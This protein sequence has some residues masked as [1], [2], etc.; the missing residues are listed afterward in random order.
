MLR[1]FVLCV[2]AALGIY[3]STGGVHGAPQPRAGGGLP[4]W[5]SF[6]SLYEEYLTELYHLVGPG[7]GPEHNREFYESNE[8]LNELWSARREVL[9]EPKSETERHEEFSEYDTTA[10]RIVAEN[11]REQ[12]TPLP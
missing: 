1:V 8:E 4:E 5:D 3:L 7:P 11:H 2:V 9:Q 6:E 12:P 10:Q